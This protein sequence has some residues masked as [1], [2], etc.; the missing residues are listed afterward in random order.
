MVAMLMARA[1]CIGSAIS[2]AT[3][4]DTANILGLHMSALPRGYRAEPRS[5][6]SRQ[7]PFNLLMF[8]A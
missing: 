2:M 8:F 7:L 6:I 4:A 5:R 3:M 1:G